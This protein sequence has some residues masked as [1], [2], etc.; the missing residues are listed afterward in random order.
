MGN[1]KVCAPRRQQLSH[2]NSFIQHLRL[3]GCY[4]IP[5]SLGP[6]VFVKACI[7]TY[8]WGTH[9]FFCKFADL[10]DSS[11][12]PFFESTVND[13]HKSNRSSF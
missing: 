6:D 5:D 1:I 8:I 3:T 7:Y 4:S 10:L 2:H 13:K 11:W 12:C 9:H